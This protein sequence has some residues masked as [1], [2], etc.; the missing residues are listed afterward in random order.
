M[1]I[2]EHTEEVWQGHKDEKREHGDYE[3][4]GGV[5]GDVVS[6]DLAGKR[7]EGVEAPI[8]KVMRHFRTRQSGDGRGDGGSG[9][10]VSE[11]NDNDGNRCCEL[12]NSNFL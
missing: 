1:E 8:Q 4:S 7:V 5:L 3:V 9:G 11:H 6:V 2:P 12:F 10:K